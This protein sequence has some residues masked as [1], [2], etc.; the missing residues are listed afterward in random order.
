M[1]MGADFSK[2]KTAAE[3]LTGISDHVLRLGKRLERIR[4]AILSAATELFA[5]AA[6]NASAVR[7]D[8]R[9]PSRLVKGF[10]TNPVLTAKVQAASAVSTKKEAEAIVGSVIAAIEETLTENLDRNG[11]TLKPGSFGKFSIRHRPGVFR[12]NP[13]MGESKTTSA[14]R[15]VKFIALG[16]LRHLEVAV[17][18]IANR[19][20]GLS[21]AV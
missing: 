9:T 14:K 20:L 11:F 2:I 3:E 12:K 6:P 7:N 16:R 13:F 19:E 18:N 1:T 5:H 4:E 10:T 17:T 8:A 21:L 15:K